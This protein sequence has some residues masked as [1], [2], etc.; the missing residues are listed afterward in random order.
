MIQL[1]QACLL[2]KYE[3]QV[4]RDGDPYEYHSGFFAHTPVLLEIPYDAYWFLVVDSNDRR[5]TVD[6]EEL[7]DRKPVELLYRA[8]EDISGAITGVG[9]G[10]FR[11]SS[12]IG[13]QG[14]HD[15]NSGSGRYDRDRDDPR[16]WNAFTD[17]QFNPT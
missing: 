16:R 4:D 12:H 7:F 3:Y 11:C 17:D 2:D 9:V 1:T 13:G 14:R 8:G 5:I 15:Y 10:A 6:V